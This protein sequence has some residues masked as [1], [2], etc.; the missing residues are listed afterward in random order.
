MPLSPGTMRLEF[1][2]GAHNTFFQED[3]AWR[4]LFY[5]SAVPQGLHDALHLSA[6]AT[7]RRLLRAQTHTKYSWGV[8]D[9]DTN[10]RK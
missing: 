3:V 7:A 6:T 4:W 1:G 9:S 5:A 8:V 10:I 2:T